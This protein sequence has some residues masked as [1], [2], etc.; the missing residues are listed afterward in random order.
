MLH[1]RTAELGRI[2]QVLEA[3]RLSHGG[4]LQVSGEAGIGK[5]ALLDAAEAS[6]DGMLVL[7]TRGVEVDSQ[8]PFAGLFDLFRPVFPL[9]DE[10]PSVQRSAL[11]GAV[12]LGPPVSADRFAIATGTLALLSAAAEQQPVLAIVD[13][14]QWL[15]VPSRDALVFSARR[16]QRDPI[17]FLWAVRD[18]PD[19]SCDWGFPEVRPRPLDDAAAGQLLAARLA[20]PVH[21]TA[22]RQLVAATGG[23]PLALIELTR[24]LTEAQLTGQEP[25]PPALP[26]GVSAV[27][28]LRR[29]VQALDDDATTVLSL[30]TLDST[31]D[32]A[33]IRRAAALQ[34]ADYRTAI[35]ELERESLIRVEFARPLL[36]HPLVRGAV[37]V[38]VDPARRRAAHRALAEA[39]AGRPDSTAR[40]WHLAAAATE[41]DEEVAAA[42]VGAARHAQA[43]S[44]YGSAASAFERAAGVTPEHP[45]RATRLLMAATAA[46]LAGSATEARRLLA[47]ASECADTPEASAR[48]DCE[49]ARIEL[50][51]GDVGYAQQLMMS[52]AAALRRT[53]P[54]VAAGIVSQAAFAAL[55]TGDLGHAVDLARSAQQLEDPERRDP[56]VGLTLG[57]SLL[58]HGDVARSFETLLAA[59]ELAERRQA[60]LDPDYV[61]FAA[62]ALTWVGETTRARA[63][64]AGQLAGAREEA[65][66]GA[67]CS[68]LYGAA[69][70]EA[71]TGHLIRGYALATEGVSVAEAT[72]NN[73]WRYLSLCCLAYVEAAQVREQECREHAHQALEIARR[74]GFGYPAPALDALGLLELALG[75]ADEAVEHLRSSNIRGGTDQPTFARL[76]GPDLVE[77]YVRAGHRLPPALQAEVQAVSGA[78]RFPGA[79]AVAWRCR[80]LLATDEEFDACFTAALRLHQR[81]DNP[82]ALARTELSYGERLRRAG[83]RQDAR[84]HLRTA[85]EL[86]T[87]LGAGHWVSRGDAEL[88]AAGVAGEEPSREGLA[89]LTPQ[90]LQVALTVAQGTTNREAGAI[91]YVSPKTV[92]FHLSQVYRKLGVRSRAE[93]AARVARLEGAAP[94]SAVPPGPLAT[95]GSRSPG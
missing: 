75:N 63:L 54:H 27:Q 85:V 22:R 50:Y 13:D 47:L 49:R 39:L 93:L 84:R 8:L 92:E 12:G 71:R 2:A 38:A 55:F 87:E 90:E 30:L 37:E 88:R 19:Q 52:A 32:G 17:A 40:A 33:V 94:R 48:V 89:A 86:L 72:G 10:L 45:I 57:L 15:D 28:V 25:F 46:R 56:V 51:H 31:G 70:L 5:S 41:P 58:H 6:S 36:T 61:V 9:I 11:Q 69:Y 62:L 66:F 73:F 1:G 16:L 76:S 3:A 18:D 83:R 44:A 34:R 74:Y 81:L 80:G 60:E 23:N 24:D 65:A 42:M 78:E 68:A 26:L 43:R 77:A 91:L 59:A 21:A 79:A 29:R 20:Q 67:L 64:L 14:A 7:R 53:D 82:F 95:R 35:E 4:V